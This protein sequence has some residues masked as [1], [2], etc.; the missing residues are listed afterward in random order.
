MR[1]TINIYIHLLLMAGMVLADDRHGMTGMA[2]D[3]NFYL[4][5]CD[6]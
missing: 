6:M 1:K 3:S 2:G 4:V 5:T